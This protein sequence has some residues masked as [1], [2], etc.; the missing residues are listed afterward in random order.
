MISAYSTFDLVDQDKEDKCKAS[1]CKCEKF[2]AQPPPG[3][4]SRS[5][6]CS[7]SSAGLRAPNFWYFE[8]LEVSVIKAEPQRD[9]SLSLSIWLVGY[10]G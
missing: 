2:E 4:G 3:H 10:A 8:G 6:H 7:P 9:G 1:D 5:G